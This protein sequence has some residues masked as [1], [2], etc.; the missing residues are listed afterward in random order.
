MDC[1][2]TLKKTTIKELKG[3]QP[4][5][6]PRK[7]SNALLCAVVNRSPMKATRNGSMFSVTLCNEDQSSTIRAVCFTK[8]VFSK[9]EPKK[10][11][12]LEEFKLKQSYGDKSASELLLDHEMKISLSA[13]QVA[14]QHTAHTIAQ[15]L[16]GETTSERF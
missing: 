5:K 16:R 10:T 1:Q 9:I 14:M 13:T 8:D 7:S 2:S 6:S 3:K 15:I 12:I 11:Y 4:P